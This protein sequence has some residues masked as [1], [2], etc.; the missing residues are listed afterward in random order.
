MPISKVELFPSTPVLQKKIRKKIRKKCRV[1][2][3][4]V[5]NVAKQA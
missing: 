1:T 5:T 3:L 2:L 4:S